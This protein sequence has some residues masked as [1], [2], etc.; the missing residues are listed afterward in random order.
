LGSS[1]HPAP[2]G[3]YE[4]QDGYLALSLSPIKTIREALGGPDELAA[5]EDPKAAFEQREDI[6]RIL[7][8]L[9]RTRTTDEWVKMLRHHAVW[10]APVHDYEQMMRDPAI[11]HLDPFLDMEHPQAGHVRVLKHPIRYSGGE[12]IMTR[13]PPALGEHTDEVLG[14]LGYTEKEIDALHDQEAV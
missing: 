9:L 6:Y 11:Q 2:Y 12:A 8:P 14:E 4:T 3:I 13:L 1:F 5:Y 7:A 10:V